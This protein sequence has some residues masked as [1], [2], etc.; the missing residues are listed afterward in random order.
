MTDHSGLVALKKIWGYSPAGGFLDFKFN[1][2]R[3]ADGETPNVEQ[4]GI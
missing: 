2:G 3:A 1:S 4:P